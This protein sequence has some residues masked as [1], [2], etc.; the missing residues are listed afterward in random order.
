MKRFVAP[1]L[2]LFVGCSVAALTIALLWPDGDAASNE[3]E[4]YL[5]KSPASLPAVEPPAQFDFDSAPLE[6][7]VSR[8]DDENPLLLGRDCP[9]TLG[10]E[11]R[12][13]EDCLDAVEGHFMDR[14]AYVVQHFG[15]APRD[16]PFT[17]REMLEGAEEDRRLVTEALSRPECR[18]LEGPIRPH[19]GEICNAEAFFRYGL[20][21]ELC[22]KAVVLRDY[23]IP[24]DELVWGDD[25]EGRTRFENAWAQYE[26]EME[27]YE[28]AMEAKRREAFGEVDVQDLA[29]RLEYPNLRSDINLFALIPESAG[30]LLA[31][32]ENLKPSNPIFE[33]DTDVPLGPP[34]PYSMYQHDLT[35]AEQW[36]DEVPPAI[37]RE[38]WD[39][40]RGWYY[41]W[42]NRYRMEALRG[43]WLDSRGMCPS[44]VFETSPPVPVGVSPDPDL[45][46][47]WDGSWEENAANEPEDEHRPGY[48]PKKH[49]LL[50][51]AVRLGDERLIAENLFRE[52][53]RRGQEFYR[54]R[55]ELFPWT[56]NLDRIFDRVPFAERFRRAARGFVELR[57]AGYK[58]DAEEVV[59]VLCRL[60]PEQV[61]KSRLPDCATAIEEAERGLDS[62]A[63]R[64][65]DEI[66]AKA[67]EMGIHQN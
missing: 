62:D 57:D 58:T 12:T 54:S 3:A 14:P 34:N 59:R 61:P 41:S 64:M 28:L 66:K 7:D 13:D 60:S 38:E 56:R 50:E 2:L 9:E 44:H 52:E 33:M 4:A 8:A 17:F 19:L 35:Y 24:V 22:N 27:Q 5:E 45:M 49:S 48:S 53:P 1:L 46:A 26:S 6:E 40:A 39:D 20:L 42:R 16:A 10:D 47:T 29:R 32:M 11:V 37:I 21:T 31:E 23:F 55:A 67:I 18:L 43:I 65:L 25:V 36:S 15:M 51:I 63:L 30:E